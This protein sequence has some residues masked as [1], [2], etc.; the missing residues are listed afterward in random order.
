MEGRLEHPCCG[1]FTPELCRHRCMSKALELLGIPAATPPW[2]PLDR[3]RHGQALYPELHSLGESRTDC[4]FCWPCTNSQTCLERKEAAVQGCAC[5][6]AVSA[7]SDPSDLNVRVSACWQI[8][9]GVS[10]GVAEKPS[11]SI[12]IISI[13]HQGPAHFLSSAAFPIHTKLRSSSA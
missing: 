1:S 8:R 6:L 11:Y 13:A 10:S 9:S 12:D 7:Q 5:V 2:C 3:L 4:C